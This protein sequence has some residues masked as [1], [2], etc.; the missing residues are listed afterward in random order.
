MSAIEKEAMIDQIN[1]IE[2]NS[3]IELTDISW[4][5]KKLNALK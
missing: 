5:Q 1:S 3:R 2:K 4:Y